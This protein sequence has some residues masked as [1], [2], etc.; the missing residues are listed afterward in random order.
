MNKKLLYTLFCSALAMSS[1]AY[2]D[3]SVAPKIQQEIESTMNNSVACWNRG[4]LPCFMSYYVKINDLL[5]ISGTKFI[6][7][8][9]NINQRYQQ[10]YG[11]NS[12]QMGQLKLSIGGIEALG[13]SHVLLYG[14]FHLAIESKTYDG[15]TSLILVKS[16]DKWKIMADHSN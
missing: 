5:F 7:G 13:E 6:Y 12:Q 10:R 16:A 15:V 2:A 14:K 1:A 11:N 4:D 8:W 9:D 3:E